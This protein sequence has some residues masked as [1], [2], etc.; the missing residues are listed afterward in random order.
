MTHD[1]YMLQVCN[2]DL[3]REWAALIEEEVAVRDWLTF[4]RQLSFT[5]SNNFKKKHKYHTNLES[6]K[7]NK[8]GVKIQLQVPV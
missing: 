2:S 4:E 8:R 1:F 3:Y 5:H 7:K 6:G